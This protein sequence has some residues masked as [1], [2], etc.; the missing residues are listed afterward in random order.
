MGKKPKKILELPWHPL[1]NLAIHEASH[2]VVGL[3]YDHSIIH[4]EL[5]RV[6]GQV[7]FTDRSWVRGIPDHRE[8]LAIDVAGCV[9]EA[10]YTERYDLPREHKLSWKGEE[11]EGDWT[12]YAK[13]MRRA[14]MICR[15]RL[16]TRDPLPDGATFEELLRAERRAERILVQKWDQ[17][18]KLAYSLMVRVSGRMT[19]KQVN[20]LLGRAG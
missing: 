9:G 17:V 6:S 10:I 13:A 18:E 15:L 14:E 7:R 20:R 19:G 4:I 5:Y 1:M 8:N 11:G 3:H 12:D 16:K 2:A